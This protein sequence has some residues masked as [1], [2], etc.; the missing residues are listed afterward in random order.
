MLS[1]TIGSREN[2]CSISF[3]S[4]GG[5]FACVCAN[6][7]DVIRSLLRSEDE[8]CVRERETLR[9]VPMTVLQ[10]RVRSLSI[11]SR[12]VFVFCMSASFVES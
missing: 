12:Y 7:V 8:T 2:H 4:P 1:L 6:P 10:K 5:L 11:D 9:R 3:F